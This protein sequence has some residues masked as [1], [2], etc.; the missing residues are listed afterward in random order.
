V[1]RSAPMTTPS[2]RH[3]CASPSPSHKSRATA[4]GSRRHMLV[5]IEAEVGWLGRIRFTVLSLSL[6]WESMDGSRGLVEVNAI[7]LIEIVSRGAGSNC[8]LN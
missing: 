1:A 2:P 6:R 4:R 3:A 7:C 5:Y 8:V